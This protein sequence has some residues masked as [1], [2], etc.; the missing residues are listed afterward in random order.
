MALNYA[1]PVE[2]DD[3]SN[4]DVTPGGVM[5]QPQEQSQAAYEAA[6]A[7]HERRLR[8]QQNVP[9]NPYTGQPDAN[10]GYG[11]STA[12]TEFRPQA[13]SMGSGFANPAEMESDYQKMQRQRAELMNAA[14]SKPRKSKMLAGMLGILFGS[15]GAE[16]WYLGYYGRAAVQLGLTI[17]SGG[18]LAPISSLWGVIDGI[19]IMASGPDSRS[20]YDANGNLL[21]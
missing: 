13:A 14:Q 10:Y 15:L 18:L 17:I 3:P 12:N 11:N 5:S 21:V 8:A 4:A 6:R 2:F 1:G 9:I 20:A 7:E 16:N 19:K